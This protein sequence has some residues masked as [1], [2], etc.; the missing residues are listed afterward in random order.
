MATALRDPGFRRTVKLSLERSPVRE[1]KLHLQSFLEGNGAVERKRVASLAGIDASLL[2][3]DLASS[4]ALELYFPV[5]AHREAWQGGPDLLVATAERD[6][7]APIAFDLD[8]G[9]RL[10]DP[11]LPPTTPVLMVEPAETDFSPAPGRLMCIDGCDAGS[12]GGSGPSGSTATGLYLTQ[13]AFTGTFESWFKGSPEF[14]VHML[15]QDGT[16]DKM[17]SYQC[18]GE[19]AGGAYSFDQ[20]GTTWSGNVL[21]F[22]DMQ[23][24][25]Y[26]Q[27]HPSTNLRIL[28]L[29]D[30]DGA[31]QIK[32]DST[33][34]ANLLKAVDL[35][36]S[37]LTAGTDVKLT[38]LTRAWKAA[39][40]LF[41]LLAA[42]ASWITTPDDLVG[43]AVE[44]PMAA[45]GFFGG[46]NWV[47]RGENN[48]ITGA[49]RL[50]MR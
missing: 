36:Y 35:A 23:L 12:G 3:Q 16:S 14:E 33:R 21:L 32:T 50:E 1:H 13:T 30:D 18:A 47:V 48:V 6:G 34:T 4:T 42:A 26:K 22:S 45:S 44:D 9:R 8:G 17:I 11:D 38:S 40:G 29:E 7:E 20:N 2:A 27:Q 5:P 41:K 19:H 39:T 25:T 46:A 10:L 15:G 31:C 43:N 49:L 37:S 28:V 24:A